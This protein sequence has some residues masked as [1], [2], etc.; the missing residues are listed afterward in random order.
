MTSRLTS[1]FLVLLLM[2][3]VAACC[4]NSAVDCQDAHADSLYLRFNLQDSTSGQGFRAHEVDS[5]VVIRKTRPKTATYTSPDTARVPPD[6][7]RIVRLPSAVGEAILLEHAAPFVRKGTRRLPDYT[8]TI[9]LPNTTQKLRFELTEL[10][11]AG[12]FEADGCVTCYR[13]RKKK[14]LVNGVARDVTS[15]DGHTEVPVVLSR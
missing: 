5:V 9:L 15:S 8:Y 1:T 7:V 11:I 2:L 3:L 4:G 12:D 13:N 6:T 10:D 14:L